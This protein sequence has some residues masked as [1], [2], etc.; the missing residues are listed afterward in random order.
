MSWDYSWWFQLVNT[1]WLLPQ[2]LEKTKPSTCSSINQLVITSSRWRIVLYISNSKSTSFH[3]IKTL[4]TRHFLRDNF[5]IKKL[6]FH[7]KNINLK[8]DSPRKTLRE[9]IMSN[10]ID[11]KKKI[12][13][14]NWVNINLEKVFMKG[15]NI[16]ELY[17]W[18]ELY[19]PNNHLE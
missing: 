16:K 7:P 8:Q 6:N 15:K 17:L 4:L 5:M 1:S 13:V 3:E 18:D 12:N 19:R 11:R 10:D 14:I 9:G 2:Y